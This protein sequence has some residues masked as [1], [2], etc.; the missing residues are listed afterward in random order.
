MRWYDTIMM[1][2]FYE[3]SRIEILVQTDSTNCVGALELLDGWL[4]PPSKCWKVWEWRVS[5]I[6][7]IPQLLTGNWGTGASGSEDSLPHVG[8]C[9][10]THIFSVWLNSVNEICDELAAASGV[11]PS[12][13]AAG[14][15][16]GF[17]VKPNHSKKVIGDV[18][19]HLIDLCSCAFWPA[20]EEINISDQ[21][22]G[23][24]VV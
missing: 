21:P 9:I 20:R 24:D 23:S 19:K 16:V 3:R 1:F 14:T 2:I 15:T 17:N 8:C 4:A 12:P 18:I 7:G 10:D 22:C 6:M 13:R 5:I 11:V